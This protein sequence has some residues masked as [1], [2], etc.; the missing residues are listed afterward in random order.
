MK[1]TE[2]I[3]PNIWAAKNDLVPSTNSISNLSKATRAK[4]IAKRLD[5]DKWA[6]K[7]YLLMVT[8]NAASKGER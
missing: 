7:S 6:D 5:K 4:T 1:R 8:V 2:P 3:I